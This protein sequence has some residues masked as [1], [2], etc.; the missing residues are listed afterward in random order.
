[1]TFNL[2]VHKLK[3]LVSGGS[4]PLCVVVISLSGIFSCG[5]K[6]ESVL[7]AGTYLVVFHGGCV[8]AAVQRQLKGKRKLAAHVRNHREAEH[9]PGTRAH[10]V[11]QTECTMKPPKPRALQVRLQ[12]QLSAA[13]LVLIS[14]QHYGATTTS[15]QLA[16]Q[17][18]LERTHFS[19]EGFFSREKNS[20]GL[21]LH[22]SHLKTICMS[23]TQRRCS[24]CRS[25]FPR[26]SVKTTLPP[27]SSSSV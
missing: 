19:R 4:L 23:G 26:L 16:A 11:L 5:L 24:F 18:L 15:T 10:C 14:K 2:N 1:M 6:R 12:A 20:C 17:I 7:C 13:C 21:I 8:Q 22:E 25:S 9:F 3:R 27:L